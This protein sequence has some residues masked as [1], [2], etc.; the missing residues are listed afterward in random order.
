MINI[1]NRYGEST[2]KWGKRYKYGELRLYDNGETNLNML[3]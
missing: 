2:N 3:T 1:S